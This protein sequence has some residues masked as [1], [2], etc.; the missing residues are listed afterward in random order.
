VT[1]TKSKNPVLP[2]VT[3]TAPLDSILSTLDSKRDHRQT[4][5]V[6]DD[7][8]GVA[9]HTN[10]ELLVFNSIDSSVV[11][12]FNLQS[13]AVLCR[14]PL[15]AAEDVN[16]CEFD[17][18]NTK[19]PSG[20]CAEQDD[21]RS[22]YDNLSDEEYELQMHTPRSRLMTGSSMWTQYS[23]P[24]DGDRVR[25]MIVSN[26][27]NMIGQHD[28]NIDN[29]NHPT[30]PCCRPSAAG[31]APED[32]LEPVCTGVATS[33]MT[34]DFVYSEAESGT[35]DD[36]EYFG[37]RPQRGPSLP[38]V[39]RTATIEWWCRQG[40][41]ET[42][43]TLV[44]NGTLNRNNNGTRNR[45]PVPACQP[46]TMT[47]TVSGSVATYQATD[48]HWSQQMPPQRSPDVIPAL[49]GPKL[50][51]P[52]NRGHKFPGAKIGDFIVRLA[53]KKPESLFGSLVQ[54]FIQCTVNGA[55][56]NP[57]TVVQNVR[58]FMNGIKNYLTNGSEIELEQ[59]VQT[60]RA[61]MQPNEFLN[62]DAV[63][64]RALLKCIVK[65]LKE[66]LYRLF[67]YDYTRNGN[68][69]KLCD[70]LK[71]ARTMT[72]PRASRHLDSH[73]LSS[74]VQHFLRSIENTYSPLKKLENLLGAMALIS[75]NV[76]GNYVGTTASRSSGQ[77]C[78]DDLLSMTV[79][80]LAQ[81]NMLSAEIEANY[82]WGL[83]QQSFLVGDSRFYLTTFSSAVDQLKNLRRTTEQAATSFESATLM[84][85]S[86]ID[87][88][89]TVITPDE[90]CDSIRK[91]SLPVRPTMAARDVCCM[92]AH[93]LKITNP[94]DYS[95]FSLSSGVETWLH[96]DAIIP[97]VVMLKS[98]IDQR[99]R[100]I[101]VYKRTQAHFVWSKSMTDV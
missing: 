49:T 16:S 34:D 31:T 63:M 29:N 32:R 92:M 24:W 23:L 99:Q 95:L 27:R 69:Q 86:D 77:L 37:T 10:N 57:R 25:E 8:N 18:N 9:G 65:P 60:F 33:E 101:Y 1:C 80:L 67:E 20:H 15:S 17:N 45:L 72:P 5:R 90:T 28:N 79:T 84:S 11:R 22:E 87:G 2:H 47:T 85:L 82:M 98:S 62:L 48:V 30:L 50:I 91:H 14:C 55:E 43:G 4:E 76:T 96:D 75:S 19:T 51:S 88:Y 61:Q 6:S 64:E 58:Q 94:Q 66:H 71:L 70:G 41:P 21:C 97:S 13:T 56:K 40:S 89:I 36:S 42:N 39:D 38:H 35:A 59:F 46:V 54:N 74:E 78:T 12:N 100:T 81:Q 68:L 93:R 7:N 52:R 3:V 26:R 53:S 44:M 73:S 83:I